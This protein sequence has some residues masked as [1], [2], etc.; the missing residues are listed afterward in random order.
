ML[1]GDFNIDFLK[2]DTNTDSK[3][4]L[5]SMY[6]NFLLPYISI[7]TSITTHSKRL[8]D[9]IF[10][11]N[12]EDDLISGNITTTITDHYAEFLLKKDIKLQHTN[13]KLFQHNLKNF[14]HT[15]FDFELKNTDWI[16]IL[17]ADKKDIDISFNKFILK[18]VSTMF[19]HMI[20]FHQ[21]TA[22]QKLWKYF[23][24]HPKS[25][26]HYQDIQIFV[27]PSSS[28]F[29]PFSHCFRGCSKIN[30]KVYDVI[31]CLNKNLITHFV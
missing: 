23:L 19:C 5:D 17:Q 8:T 16:T 21:M 3:I 20:I 2:Y 28:L 18:L 10:S 1:L 31:N 15:Q 7:P 22:L 13:Q 4:L 9:N 24:F 30:L 11:N 25:S 29:L 27:F 26:F 14:N 12:I 6:T